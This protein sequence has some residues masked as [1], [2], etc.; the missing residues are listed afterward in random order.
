VVVPVGDVNPTSR[1]AVV[2]WALLALNVGVFL[3]QASQGRCEQL[4]FL[5]RWAIVPTELIDLQPLADADVAALIGRRCAATVG[6]KWVVASPVTAMFLHGGLGH[7]AGNMLFLAVF[8]NNV[9]DR[10]GRGRFLAFYLLGG[11]VAT[12][13]YV[14]SDP[15]SA[16]PLV[17]A[18]GAVSAVLGAYLVLY[19]RARVH[20]Y[21][22]FPLYLV[23]PLVPGMRVTG[24]FLFF[25]VVTM[26][27]FVVLTGWF[28]LQLFASSAPLAA[29][30]N[31]AYVA[32]IVGFA[33]GMVLLAVLR[34]R[35]RRHG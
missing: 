28:V 8:G 29:Q 33:A 1:R 27:A 35:P 12:L 19:P 21:V 10:L 15:A 3:W 13:G 14:A 32:H 17:G 7:L 5:Y 11:V 22:P 20:T 31:V 23:A 9:E 18:S 30:S 25:A 2:T 4:A 6:D 26:P 34:P 16:Q 24:F